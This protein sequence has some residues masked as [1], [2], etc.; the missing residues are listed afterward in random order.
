MAATL[1]DS[2]H[3]CRTEWRN[4]ALIARDLAGTE[5]LPDTTLFQI[6]ADGTNQAIKANAPRRRPAGGKRR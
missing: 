2:D 5:H 6:I 4:F 3:R 1:K